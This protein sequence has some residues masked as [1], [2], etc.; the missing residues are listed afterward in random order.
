[1]KKIMSRFLVIIAS[2]AVM[3]GCA[4]DTEDVPVTDGPVEEIPEVK[5]P[6]TIL[7]DET[8]SFQD[9]IITLVTESSITSDLPAAQQALAM[10]QVNSYVSNLAEGLGISPDELYFRRV[11]YTYPSA[12]QYGGQQDLSAM[13]LW[14]GTMEDGQWTDFSPERICLMEHFTITSDA[15]CPSVGTPL[16]AYINGN[17]LVIMPD[18]I[19]YGST[20]DMV[21]PYMNHTICA[22]NSVDALEAG[23]LMF[24]EN[25]SADMS[26]DWSTVV[27]GASQGAGNALAVQKYMETEP[28]MADQWNFSHSYCAAGPYNPSLTLEIYLEKGKTANPV[29]MTLTLNSMYD[30]YPD[31]FGRFSEDLIYSETYLAYKEE[32]DEAL[33]SKKYTTSELN[34]MLLSYLKPE[35]GSDDVDD[36]EL[37]LEDILSAEILDKDSEVCMALYECLALNDLT[38]GWTPQH[39]IKLYCSDMDSVVPPENAQ[40]VE[41]AF[42]DEVVTV[43][44]ALPFDHVLHCA[45]WMIDIMNNNYTL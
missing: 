15:E 43:V 32:L 14:L 11:T 7:T 44:K 26:Q 34:D 20:V 35:S 9:F 42:G 39:P 25:S 36:D 13:A 18:Y 41:D 2:A 24:E 17:S 28:G 45:L 29:L 6:Y 12:D 27:A 23:Y 30:S 4:R 1:M 31:I 3:L 37:R 19:G 33:S 22:L 38:K 8:C 21:H 16:E 10:A 5:P 40:S